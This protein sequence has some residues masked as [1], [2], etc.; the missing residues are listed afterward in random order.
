MWQANS[1]KNDEETVR[2]INAL[3]K[4]VGRDRFLFFL[5]YFFD[6]TERRIAF[7]QP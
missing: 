5:I 7:I 3:P 2:R 6:D 4:Y 1:H